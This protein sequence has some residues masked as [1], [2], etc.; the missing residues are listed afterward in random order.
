MSHYEISSR[1]REDEAKRDE[2]DFGTSELE[3]EDQDDRIRR[4]QEGPPDES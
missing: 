4:A 1:E 2:R 3:A